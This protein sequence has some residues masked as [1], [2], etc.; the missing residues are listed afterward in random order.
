MR[1]FVLGLLTFPS[2]PLSPPPLNPTRLRF[3][4][5]PVTPVAAPAVA[6]KGVRKRGGEFPSESGEENTQKYPLEKQTRKLL[7]CHHSFLPSAVLMHLL[8]GLFS[9]EGNTAR[10][11]GGG[12]GRA[13]A[14]RSPLRWAHLSAEE[15]GRGRANPNGKTDKRTRN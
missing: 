4:D 12:G 1:C 8:P 13:M 2:L 3:R 11:F 9:E 7:F 15:G 6:A 5:S 10:T 14:L